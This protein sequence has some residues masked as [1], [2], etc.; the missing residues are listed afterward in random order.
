MVH[1]TVSSVYSTGPNSHLSFSVG[2]LDAL[3]G[4]A[5]RAFVRGLRNGVP[6]GVVAAAGL[7]LV[8]P[9]ALVP[10]PESLFPG[11][12]VPR[13]RTALEHQRRSTTWST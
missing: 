6:D 3:A 9:V 2:S 11:A 7:G 10:A 8:R 12:A 1:H 4:R 13:R 5:T